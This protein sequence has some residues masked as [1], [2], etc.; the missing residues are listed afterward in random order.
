MEEP[1]QNPLLRM[2]H[3]AKSFPGIQALQDVSVELF[4]GEVLALIGEN[5]AGKSTLIKTLGGAIQPDRGEIEIDGSPIRITSPVESQQQGIGIIYQEFNLLPF[6]TVREN[7]FLGRAKQSLGVVN[8]RKER[9]ATQEL[10]DRLGADIH[11]DALVSALSIAEQQLVEIA[12]AL[13]TD[14]KIVVMDEPTATLTP[15]E[16]EQLQDVVRELTSQGIG[17]IY[18][19]HRLNEVLELADRVVVL[20]DGKVVGEKDIALTN[21]R[22][23]IE[24]MVGRKIEDEFP[25]QHQT[26]GPTRLSVEGLTWSDK[27]ID[28]NF[29]VRSGEILGIT[30]L[31]GAG[32]TELAQLIA[33]AEIPDA[34]QLRLEGQ[35]ITLRSPRQAIRA[36]ICLLT[37]DRK[38][39]GLITNHT[40]Q[41][42]FS[43]PNLDHLSRLGLMNQAMERKSLGN[44]ANSLQIKMVSGAQLAGQLSG[45]NQQKL[46]LAKWLQLKCGLMIV[47]EPTRGIDVGAKYEIYQLM[48]EL[49][50]GGMAIIMISSE[51]PEVLGMADR[52]LVMRQG[53]IAGE[54]QSPQSATQQEIME[55]AAG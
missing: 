51:L 44:Y 26:L 30:G 38:N 6:L 47:D 4:P 53:R 14:V 55:L 36:G 3:I 48:N 50:A 49:V 18:I 46:V 43:L 12:K 37:E 20:R 39:Q 9:I 42:N 10:F 15:R 7:L 28:V 5:G 17:V 32:R 41:Q 24:W 29:S 19:S 2:T 40:I 52:I 31:M 13:V 21:R 23:L 35:L 45:G 27:V 34:G 11:P 8:A 22:Q 33:G 25:K 54:I 1:K 16:V